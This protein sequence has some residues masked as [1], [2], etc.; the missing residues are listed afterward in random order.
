MK[1]IFI[2]AAWAALLVVLI[3]IGR[4]LFTIP[5]GFNGATEALAVVGALFGLLGLPLL[6]AGCVLG[7]AATLGAG[8]ACWG[9]GTGPLS[10]SRRVAWVLVG[11]AMAAG[12]VFTLQPLTQTFWRMF[13]QKTYAGL[14]VGLSA[15]C[16]VGV[17]AV[18]GP[19][20]VRLAAAG[21]DRLGERL[22]RALDPRR[23][24]GAV[25]W[26]AVILV[27]C[28][29]PV[30]GAITAFRSIELGPAR[31]LCLWMLALAA[32]AALR[33]DRHRWLSLG[34]I[35]AAALMA[36]GLIPASIGLTAAT[37]QQ[38][39]FRDGLLSRFG[40]S[41][42]G[43]LA[44]GDGDSIPD[45]FGGNDCDDTQAAIRPGAY[46]APKDGVDQS[47]S[48]AD[49]P[50]TDPL[51]R[52]RR[53][54][55]AGESPEWHVVL[56]TVDA[57]RHDVVKPLMPHLSAVAEQSVVFENA[58]AHGAATYWSV[59]SM[60]ASTL[61]SR[62][63]M[64]CSKTPEDSVVMLPEVLDKHG[65]TT[66]M[67]TGTALF[68][69]DGLRQGI[70]HPDFKASN[71]TGAG[72]K[73]PGGHGQTSDI[74]QFLDKGPGH[75]AK[76]LFLWSHYYDPHYPYF[77]IEGFA[78]HDG[79]PRA[80]YDAIV[81]YTDVQI[82]R[83]VQRLK[84][85]KLWD[86]TVF[87]VTADHGEAFG[88]HGHRFHGQAVYDESV[89]VP[90]I[91]RIPGVAPQRIDAPIGLMD[92]STTLLDLLE[93]PTPRPWIGQ[94]WRPVLNGEPAPQTP[95]FSEILPDSNYGN[96]M[97]GMRLGRFK[98][99]RR[100]STGRDEL[101]DLSADPAETL[102]LADI[103]PEAPALKARV[104]A[105]VDH[106]L[107]LLARNKAGTYL[108]PGSPKSPDRRCAP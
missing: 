63:H 94:S 6:L 88:E 99:I 24:L 38:A 46:D 20:L 3:E 33:V 9:R 36:L 21:I 69:R 52:P 61:P 76:K 95:V 100:V 71:R 65:Y 34:A 40:A 43:R 77:E 23:A 89:K 16:L 14:A 53:T 31:L 15:V 80:K 59:P 81:R 30:I 28:A 5:T 70:K 56:I 90:L 86:K 7:G 50:G 42:M 19:V 27:I 51:P 8:L 85:R 44:D 26:A 103:A 39:V 82:G 97:V 41:A 58:Y 54:K 101:Y 29:G 35:A 2:A 102:N 93:V 48:G 105:Y 73:G 13:R 98:F 11:G 12:L 22:P 108:P 32:V 107:A 1:R 37:A 79:S 106:S 60:L 91:M 25:A 10:P 72:W 96:H 4:A 87:I 66:A 74:F 55:P 78:P 57:L 49:Y 104:T 67:F 68:F 64:A 62:L 75:D 47:C 83:L 45:A 17:M 92:V 18:I 84:D